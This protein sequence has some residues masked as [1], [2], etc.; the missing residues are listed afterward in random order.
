VKKDQKREGR[1]EG[2]M[3]YSFDVCNAFGEVWM[4]EDFQACALIL[5]PDK[6]RTSLKTILWDL[7]LALSVIGLD[8]IS[9]VLRRESMIKNHHPKE[10]FAY[11]WFIGVNPLKQNR[12]IGSAFIKEVINKCEKEKR[13]IYLETSVERNLPFYKK[14]GLIFFNHS[15]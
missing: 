1:I 15:I 11:L 12:G 14:F 7:R 10:P 9:A 5:F 2:L 3:E 13:P 8:R 6:K 4:S